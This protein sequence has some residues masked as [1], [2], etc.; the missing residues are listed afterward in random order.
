VL[1][2][3]NS[4][5]R[6]GSGTQFWRPTV[7][8]TEARAACR[9]SAITG[10]WFVKSSVSHPGFHNR[11]V[12]RLSQAASVFVTY[13]TFDAVFI[14]GGFPWKSGLVKRRRRGIFVAWEFKTNPD[15]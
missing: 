9:A 3:Q 8:V 7:L 13:G 15:T 6:S 4:P 11:H 10:P 2:A 5:L 14:F 12:S 1:R